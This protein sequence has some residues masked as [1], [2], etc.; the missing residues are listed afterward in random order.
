M[1]SLQS[2]CLSC[3]G[4]LQF[5]GYVKGAHLFAVLVFLA[6]ICMYRHPLS[7]QVQFGKVMFCVFLYPFPFSLSPFLICE[8]Q[9]KNVY[10]QESTCFC[11]CFF[12]SVWWR[13]TAIIVSHALPCVLSCF[14]FG[15]VVMGTQLSLNMTNNFPDF[16]FFF[17]MITHVI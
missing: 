14:T 7:L 17:F 9:S 6:L 11:C 16:F 2:L 1:C 8:Y 10:R 12:F 3:T 5:I 13:S 4:Q 15:F